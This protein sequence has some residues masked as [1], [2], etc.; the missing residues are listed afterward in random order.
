LPV[1]L[2]AY[3]EPA[4]HVEWLRHLPLADA[5]SVAAAV[6]LPAETVAGLTRT[7]D[8]AVRGRIVMFGRWLAEYGEPVDWRVNPVIG[9]RWFDIGNALLDATSAA[10]PGDIKFTW[11]I[12]RFPQAYSIARAAARMPAHAE[13]WAEGLIG[14]VRHFVSSNP[15]ATGVHWTSGQETGFRLLAWLFAADVLFSRTRFAKEAASVIGE[16]LIAGATYIEQDLDYAR[17]AVYNNHLLSEALALFAAGALL[18]DAPRSQQWRRT[19]RE[20]LDEESERQFYADGGYIQQ[21]HNYHRV[22]LQDLLWA[23]A[24]ARS[25]GDAPSRSWLRAMERSVDF[26]LAHQ[27]PHD[28]RLPN[29]GSNDGSLPSPLTSCDFSDFRPTLQAASLVTRG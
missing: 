16:A 23:C 18:P 22:A 27:N 2:G 15:A 24:F 4:A 13:R 25:M 3:A 26:L 5:P 21:S 9:S 28:G 14:Q 29:Y 1:D 6:H 12:A 19:G 11:E 8:D 17:I 20:I 7:A 10:A